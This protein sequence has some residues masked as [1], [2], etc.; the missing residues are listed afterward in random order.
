M[1]TRGHKVLLVC[2]TNKLAINYKE[3]G[4]TINQ[5]FG[6]GLTEGTKMAKFDGSGYGTIVFD[7]IIFCSVRNLVRIKRYCESN[8]DKIVVATGDTD[9]LECIDCI[10]NQND[11]DEYYNRCVDMIFPIGMFLRKNKRLKRKKDKET[12]KGFKQDIFD[13]STPVSQTIG[14]YFKTVEEI[15]TKYNL[16]CKELHLPCGQRGRSD[17]G[18]SRR[19]SRYSI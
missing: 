6:V 2:P 3:H 17:R 8:P 18:C 11:Y 19:A 4:C 16:A 9:Q 1:E 5:F 7:E 13:D 14:R 15:N 10:T 12:L